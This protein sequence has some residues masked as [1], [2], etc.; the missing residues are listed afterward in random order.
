ME[1]PLTISF[2]G[3]QAVTM[4]SDEDSVVAAPVVQIDSSI[5]K[6][7]VS[8][9]IEQIQSSY[10]PRPWAS[11]ELALLGA[12]EEAARLAQEALGAWLRILKARASSRRTFVALGRDMTISSVGHRSDQRSPS[13]ASLPIR[14]A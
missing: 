3:L 8:S 7:G 4:S 12:R 5:A 1:T 2:S 13:I 14:K 11:S 9:T 6:G 10:I